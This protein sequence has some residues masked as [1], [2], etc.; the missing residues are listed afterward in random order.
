MA[1][2]QNAKG[3]RQ[4][5]TP[6]GYTRLFGVPDLGN[7]M[8]RVQSAVISA[9]TELEHLI[10]ERCQ[11]IDNL[12]QF[13]SER[14]HDNE[15]GVFVAT[16]R[17]VKTS[18]IIHSSYEPDFVGFRLDKRICYVVE[19]KD[20]DQFDTKK[21][22]AEYQSLHNFAHDVSQKLPFSMQIYMCSFNSENVEDV[23]QG[24]KRKFNKDELLT[25]RG[26]CALFGIKHQD[27]IKVRISQQQVNLE[28]FV[29][30]LVAIPTVRYV[31]DKV[32]HENAEL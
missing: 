12:D 28:Y 31:L 3:R 5:Q 30:Q 25:G 16:K 6:S 19:V 2:I 26:L 13:L 7:L 29:Q 21:A 9:G 15:P 27:I 1:L 18:K 22:S 11:H 24:L 32:L 23:Y 17:Q 14:L 4:H 8:S 20:G 10:I